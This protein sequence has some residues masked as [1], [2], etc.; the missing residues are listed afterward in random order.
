L[1]SDNR[2]GEV[3]IRAFHK[4]KIDGHVRNRYSN[5]I[6]QGAYL[7]P[8]LET[9]RAV[10]L[11]LIYPGALPEE[12][13]PFYC[14]IQRLTGTITKTANCALDE[15]SETSAVCHVV[16]IWLGCGVLRCSA[17][18]EHFALTANFVPPSEKPSSN[19]GRGGGRGGCMFFHC[20]ITQLRTR[21]TYFRLGACFNLDASAL[22]DRGSGRSTELCHVRGGLTFKKCGVG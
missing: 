13:G 20:K 17:S 10:Y 8:V 2:N 7:K 21:G 9:G 5:C 12:K 14:H 19:S 3:C 15:S 18:A 4:H 6:V 1:N 16:H 11:D 22:L